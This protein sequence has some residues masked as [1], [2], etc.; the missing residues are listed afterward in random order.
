LDAAREAILAAPE[1]QQAVTLNAE[2]FKIGTLAG[3]GGIDS[4]FARRVLIWAARQ[5]PS[6]D[7]RR[8]WRA[9]DL[10]AKVNRS[11]DDGMRHPRAMR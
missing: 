11:F 8:P 9:H 4:H 3:A 1:G 5:I 10:D 6:Y 7:H 2:V